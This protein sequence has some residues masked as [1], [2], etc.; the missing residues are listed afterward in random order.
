MMMLSINDF[1]NKYGLKKHHQIKKS[2]NFFSN[3]SLDSVGIY[4]RDGLFRTV[5]G[6]VILHPSKVTHWVTYINEKYFDS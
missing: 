3:L 5:K 2:H 1:R 6:I 4:L